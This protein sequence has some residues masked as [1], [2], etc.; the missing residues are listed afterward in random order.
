ML[1]SLKLTAL[2]AAVALSSMAYSAPSVAQ[3]VEF[4][5]GPN[6]VRIRT[7]DFCERNPNDRRCRAYV[8]RHRD[9]FTGPDRNYRMPRKGRYGRQCD[10][11][12]ALNKARDMGIRRAEVVRANDRRIT[13]QGVRRGDRIRVTFGR[14]GNCSVLR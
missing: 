7:A 12:D 3:D 1:K 14:D 6:G 9:R 10:S 11:S 5:I 4:L 8:D 2:A 13:V